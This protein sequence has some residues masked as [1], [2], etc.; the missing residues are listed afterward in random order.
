LYKY[1][2]LALSK[3]LLVKDISSNGVGKLL[4]LSPVWMTPNLFVI[5]MGFFNVESIER[6]DYVV[7]VS[8]LFTCDEQK[9][10]NLTYILYQNR[11]SSVLM[12]LP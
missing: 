2:S 7:R 1:A 9:D 11:V 12:N 4:F 3:D 8:N 6:N 10:M 5:F